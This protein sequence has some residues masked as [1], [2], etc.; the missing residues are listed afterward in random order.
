MK[1]VL[2]RCSCSM[3]NENMELW[4]VDN[5]SFHVFIVGLW[6]RTYFWVA[7]LNR[8]HLGTYRMTNHD[9]KESLHMSW[10]QAHRLC[11]QRN[12]VSRGRRTAKAKAAGP[13]PTPSLMRYLY[14]AEKWMKMAIHLELQHE[15]LK[16]FASLLTKVNIW[17]WTGRICQYLGFDPFLIC[18]R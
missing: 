2:F 15:V 4:G 12:N 14:A 5:I 18:P 10:L 3:Y 8:C 7:R 6:T 1:W 16:N 11:S 9:H 17:R 13:Q